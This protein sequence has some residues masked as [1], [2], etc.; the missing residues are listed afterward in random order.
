MSEIEEQINEELSPDEDEVEDDTA[1]GDDEPNEADGGEG[2]AASTPAVRSQKEIEEL[3]GKLEREAERHAK[4]V[5][6]IMGDDFQLL[7]PNPTDWTP[8]FIFNVPQML[9]LPEQVAALDAILGRDE[10]G[11][12]LDAEDAQA[13]DKCNARGRT[14]TGSKVDGQRTKPC[15]KC[16]GTGWVVRLAAVAPLEHVYGAANTTA[17]APVTPDTYQ[18]KDSWGRPAGHPHFGIDPVAITA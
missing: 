16:N 11:E 13:C 6:E 2:N 9:P 5:A 8:G 3:T 4:R 10:E 14:R 17:S 15:A 18:V 7:V 1:L 12:L